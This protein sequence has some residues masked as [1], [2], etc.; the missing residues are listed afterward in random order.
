MTPRRRRT[1]ATTPATPQLT[2]AAHLTQQLLDAGYTKRQVGQILG[3]DPSLVSQFFT[4]GK[5]AAFIPALRRVLDALH[6]G[7][8]TSPEELH[9]IADPLVRR[10]TTTAGRNAR[11]RTKNIVGD[12]HRSSMARAGK[13]HIASGA[14]RLRPVIVDQAEVGGRIAFTVRAKKSAFVYDSGRP[15]DSPGLRRGVVQRKDGTEE[16]AYGGSLGPGTGEAGFDA[17]DWK[18]RVDATGG[19]VAAAV[20]AWLISTGRLK[21][22]AEITHLEIRGW[23]PREGR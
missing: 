9:Q 16:R 21:R 20:K 13:Q 8:A 17:S 11:V 2:E 5:G 6:H 4:K 19:D 18:A 15:K 3:R 22:D 10:R 1:R 12:T 14:S 23:R 7:A